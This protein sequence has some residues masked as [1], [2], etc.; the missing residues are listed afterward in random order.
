MN[1]VNNNRKSHSAIIW[2]TIGLLA[3]SVASTSYAAS[4]EPEGACCH[5]YWGNGMVCEMLTEHVCLDYQGYWYGPYVNCNEPQVECDLPGNIEGA[6]CYEDDHF[7]FVCAMLIEEPCIDVSGYWYGA[8]VDCTDPHV[9]CDL[10]VQKGACCYKNANN[11]VICAEL[12]EEHCLDVNGYW[13]GSGVLC[14][15]PQVDCEPQ[16]NDPGACCY[17]DPTFGFVCW[18]TIEEFCIDVNGYWYGPGVLCTDPQVECDL[19]PDPEGACCYEDADLGWIC[20]QLSP[21]H[22]LDVNGTFYGMGVLCTDPQ[23]DCGSS[24][25]DK[26][27]CCYEDADGTLNCI[28]VNAI[29]CETLAGIWYGPAVLCTDPQVDC[30]PSGDVPGACCYEDADLGWICAQVLQVQCENLPSGYWYGPGVLCTDPQVECDL[31]SGDDCI[32][33]PGA[34]CAGRP[35]YIDP[36]FSQVFGNGQIAVQTASPNIFGGHV[37]K[38]FDLSGVNSAPLDSWFSL[39]RYSDADWTQWELGSVFGVAV[40]EDGDIFVSSTRS[41]NFD[42]VGSGGWGAVYRLDRLTGDISVFAT[43]PNNGAGLGSITW[44]CDHQVFFVSNIEDGL[45]YRLDTAGNILDAFDP[46]AAWNGSAGPVAL[47]DRPLAVEVHAGRLYFSMWNESV[48]SG[49][50]ANANEIWSVQLD[51]TGMPV[52]LET[53]EISLPS[54]G[55][56]NWSAPVADMRFTPRGTMML[57]ERSLVNFDS[58]VAHRSR[59]LEYECSNGTWIP[60]G[61][62]FGVGQA[63][64]NNTSGGVDADVDRAWAGGDALHLNNPA[65]YS[66]IYGFAGL[67]ATGG[68]VADSVLVDYQDNMSGQ[69]KT[70]LGDLVVTAASTEPCFTT[71]FFDISCRSHHLHGTYQFLEFGF[72]NNGPSNIQQLELTGPSGLTITPNTFMGPFPPYQS[73]PLDTKLFNAPNG[74]SI[75]LTLTV[76][77]DDGSTCSEDICFETETCSEPGPGDV[78]YDFKVDI[79]DLLAVIENWGNQCDGEEDCMADQDGDGVVGIGDVLVVLDNWS[80]R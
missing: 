10:P 72:A 34:Q 5:E 26:G 33:V 70:M 16:N 11:N 23:V 18:Y 7:G 66:N 30:G 79:T 13:Y 62:T 3:C 56:T 29:D 24:S 22:C 20:V 4:N 31:P 69:D 77:M 35:A 80:A 73:Y 63:G 46:A 21:E 76:T 48:D 41:W 55:S 8:G 12:I 51:A 45:I 53:L 59:L 32:I 57:A 58:L 49:S 37:V 52:G 54:Y 50:S 17:D 67:P 1:T 44:D 74:Q 15:D 68:T 38:V 14:T 39:N 9:E 71:Y 42:Y 27:A 19:P 61:N 36:D 65:P 28:E 40:D 78:N 64:G 43:L 6:C 60:S 2:S 47:G 75:C 25:D